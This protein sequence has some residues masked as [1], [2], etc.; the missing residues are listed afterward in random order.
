ME[1]IQLVILN[2]IVD[3]HKPRN[4]FPSRRINPLLGDYR[5]PTSYLICCVLPLP[6]P[7]PSQEGINPDGWEWVMGFRGISDFTEDD[8]LD[9]LH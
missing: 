5:V 8:A 6:H 3:P 4:S 2:E 1:F 9:E 7:S